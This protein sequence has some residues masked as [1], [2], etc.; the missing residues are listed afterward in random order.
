MFSFN[1]PFGACPECDGL[2]SKME[3]DLDLVVP[4]K[5]LSINQGAIAPWCKGGI[6]NYYM[7]MLKAAAALKDIDLDKPFGELSADEQELILYGA[8]DRK[9]TF[10]YLNL[11]GEEKTYTCLLYTSRCV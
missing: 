5:T 10:S 2:G 11:F 4:D 1:S 3:V 8:G 9:V 6:S 7:Q